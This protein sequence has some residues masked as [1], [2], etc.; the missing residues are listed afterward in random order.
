M[1][2]PALAVVHASL[3]SSRPSPEERQK[4]VSSTAQP[5][6]LAH[7]AM[8]DTQGNTRMHKPSQNNRAGL[9]VSSAHPEQTARARDGAGVISLTTET[10]Y[11]KTKQP[12]AVGG[13]DNGGGNGSGRSDAGGGDDDAKPW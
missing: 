9:A 5:V 6:W 4:R 12:G 8:V 7:A 13:G 1:W 2:K 10:W 11:Y 3:V